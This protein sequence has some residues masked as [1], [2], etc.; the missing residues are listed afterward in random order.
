MVQTALRRFICF[1]FVFVIGAAVW[2]ADP[3]SA[4]VGKPARITTDSA[5]ASATLTGTITAIDS[6]SLSLTRP[7]D[8][9]HPRFI[10]FEHVSKLELKEGQSG[11][12]WTGALIGGL[13]GG[14]IMTLL[15]ATDSDAG[16]FSELVTLVI[17]I[18]AGS[19]A[20]VGG[21]IGWQ[22][23]SPG[24]KEVPK[25]RL[26]TVSVEPNKGGAQLVLRLNW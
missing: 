8:S 6:T 3:A 4:L 1:F 15:T 22:V 17:G 26:W 19:G 14:G 2:A 24:W 25:E 12:L 21:L 9:L 13:A 16:E 11:H 18:G 10:P 7:G 5:W 23:K 20:V